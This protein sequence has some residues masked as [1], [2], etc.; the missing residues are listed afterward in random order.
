MNTSNASN[1]TSRFAFSP[2]R[3]AELEGESSFDFRRGIEGELKLNAN[4]ANWPAQTPTHFAPEASTPV[5]AR[6]Q[7]SKASNHN[8]VNQRWHFA[9]FGIF[10]TAMSRWAR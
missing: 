6:S 2:Y 1:S 4:G 3:G 10:P 7:S 9:R 5:T 8:E